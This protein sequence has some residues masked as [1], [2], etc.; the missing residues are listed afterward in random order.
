M[1]AYK[2]SLHALLPQ[3]PQH[4][5]IGEQSILCALDVEHDE[6]GIFAARLKQR[7]QSDQGHF[8]RRLLLRLLMQCNR[9]AYPICDDA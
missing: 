1:R 5:T 8:L 6:V 2:Q 9:R 7:L 3:Q 4:A